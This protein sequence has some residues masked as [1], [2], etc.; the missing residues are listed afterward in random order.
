MSSSK[1]PKVL[2][3]AAIVDGESCEEL[4]QTEPGDIYIGRAS[5]ASLSMGP[6]LDL[7]TGIAAEGE[8]K[9]LALPRFLVVLGLLMIVIGGG[10]FA[11]E[12][13]QHVSENAVLQAPEQSSGD[14][15][16]E[17]EAGE[18]E[19]DE[20]EADEDEGDPT[21]T[22]ALTLALLG[23]IPLVTGR[24]MLRGLRR[25]RREELTVYD[26]WA[27]PRDYRKNAPIWLGLGV[28][29]VLGGGGLFVYEVEQHDPN[30]PVT[31][32]KRGDMSAFKTADGGG[33]GGLGLAI[34]LLGLVPG[35]I[36]FMGMQEAPVKP[37]KRKPKGGEAPRRHRLFE[38][39]PDE[40]VYY[41][42]IP[43]QTK[44]KLA[45]GK[46]KASVDAL[47]KRFGEGDKLRVKLGTKAKGKLLIGQTKI[48]FR[49]TKPARAA[50]ARMFPAELA[51]PLAHLRLSSLDTAAFAGVAGLAVLLAVWFVNFADR[52][53]SKPSE[54]FVR[55]MGMP[56]S[57]YEEEEEPE[58]EEDAKEDVL[59]QED[60]EEEKEQVEEE[61]DEKLDKPDN[62]SDEAF[63]QARGVGVALTL[64]TYG[65]PGEGTVLDLIQSRENNLGE[66]FDQGMATTEDYRGGEIG[67][68]VA[69]GGGIE[70]TGN[71]A[72]N[73]GLETGKGPAEVGSTKK[74]ERKVKA[75]SSTEDVVGADKK[76]VSAT[77]R[78]RMPGL[79]ACYE[80]ALQSNSSLSG[81]MTYTIT[82]NT[83][84]RVTDVDIEVDTV[85]DASVRSCTTAKIKAW[86]FLVED[87]EESA[88]VTFSVAFTG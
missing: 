41:I 53:P 63:E 51:D 32:A 11:Y 73:E 29:M 72:K 64:G 74:K 46:N 70:S 68:F 45:L 57:F 54:R 37:R 65:G 17:G 62:V 18:G 19:A 36:G 77:I 76:G 59:K 60:K 35:V 82:I 75:K 20:G 15:A 85:G 26:G 22:I 49:T 24:T 83:S 81:K 52:T 48:I 31:D 43:A 4:H 50:K 23:V 55:E 21:S 87:A 34:A 88:E 71:V 84:G 14:A 58:P 12:V 16:G 86:R 39:V 42:D 9:D 44:G 27:Q 80:R 5:G 7:E 47:R 33:T 10:W 79:E 56:A 40:G 38:W 30:A 3:V 13:N 2:R 6:S 69:G 28:V 67:D 25:R 78:R 66:L 61:L 1:R 8:D